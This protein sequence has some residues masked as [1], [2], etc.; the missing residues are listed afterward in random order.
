[1][2]GVLKSILMLGNGSTTSREVRN[3]AW[4]IAPKKSLTHQD[5]KAFF[6]ANYLDPEVKI[7]ET[8]GG[9]GVEYLRI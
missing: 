1:M 5:V 3:T 2:E 9:S 6:A 4:S 8:M 7:V